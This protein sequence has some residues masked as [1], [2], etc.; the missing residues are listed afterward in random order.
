MIF[1][2]TEMNDS[3]LRILDFDRLTLK[4]RVMRCALGKGGV[5]RHKCE[6]DHATPT[7]R[8]P[9]RRLLYRADRVTVPATFLPRQP[10]RAFDGWCDDP[11]HPAYN[12]P[13]RLPFDSHHEVLWRDDHLYDLCVP[14]GYNDHPA[15]PRKGS[16]IF[17][18][19][20]QE[21]YSGTEGCIALN[22]EDLTWVLENISFTSEVIIPDLLASDR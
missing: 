9:F 6:G 11:N 19:L 4:N 7:G 1:W 5:R 13:V 22:L 16:A 12:C 20:A 14:L 18:H 2:Q 10:I 8:F 21:D 17:M 3:H 15:V